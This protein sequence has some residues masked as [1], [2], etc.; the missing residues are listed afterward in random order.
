MFNNSSIIYRIVNYFKPI[1]N[2][3]KK[4]KKIK[5][6]NNLNNYKKVKQRE[7]EREIHARSIHTKT[8]NSN[9]GII[10]H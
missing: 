1:K 4:N 8:N 3:T 6:I 9:N 10:T 5:N 2:F 7:R